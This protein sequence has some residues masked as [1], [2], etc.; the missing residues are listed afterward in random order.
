VTQYFKRDALH[1]PLQLSPEAKQSAALAI[2][3][4]A[5]AV[6]GYFNADDAI[7]FALVLGMQ[8]MQGPPGDILEIG[9]W[10]GR[11]AGY[12][13]AFLQ[14]G[15]RLVVCDAFVRETEDHYEGRPTE[16]A[17]R[18]NIRAIAPLHDP[19]AL[20]IHNCLSSELKL[21]PDAVFRCAHID[22]GHSHA[23]ALA[24]FRLV[25]DHVRP[26]GLMI[27]DDYE[28]KDWPGVTSAVNAFLAERRDYLVMAAANRWEA[29]GQ[30]LYLAR[31]P[32]P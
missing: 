25:A 3:G 13:A 29:K 32:A 6:P 5:S 14:P 4:R 19:A 20:V 10:F 30:K 28:H 7:H 23:Q 21:P 17:L 12:M 27:I 1:V 26:G 24:D 11:S 31:K 9:T 2:F 15:E 18:A 8:N 22:G 16:Q